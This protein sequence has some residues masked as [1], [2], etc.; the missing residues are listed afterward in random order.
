MRL[1]P[2]GPPTLASTAASTTIA[3]LAAGLALAG[4]GSAS[5]AASAVSAVAPGAA[6][7]TV[8]GPPPSAG[9]QSAP[10]D[11][12]LAG[13]HACALIPA[14]TV[15]ATLGQLEEPPTESSDGLACFFNTRQ[16][17]ESAGPSYIL[18]ITT[19]SAYEVTKSLADGEAE[20]KLVR[21]VPIRGIGD[22][23]YSTADSKGG[24]GYNATVAKGGAAA[25]IQVNSVSPADE[26]QAQRLL[27]VVVTHL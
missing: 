19:R 23:G 1:W 18:D 2:A 22:E 13:L 20:A 21:L 17:S 24:P 3:L 27:A 9:D 11:R 15:T 10:A 7:A 4:C 12:S 26:Q 16:N 8:P 14:A 5:P 25:A 6:S